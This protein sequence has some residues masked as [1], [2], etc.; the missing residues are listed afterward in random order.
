MKEAIDF[1]DEVNIEREIKIAAVLSFNKKLEMMR[2]KQAEAEALGATYCCV[3]RMKGK[4]IIVVLN[5]FFYLI[6][7]YFQME[8]VATNQP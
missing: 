7:F 4:F 1:Q 2:K 6:F 3:V 5:F 8:S